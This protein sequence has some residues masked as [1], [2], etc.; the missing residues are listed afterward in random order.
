M[1][2]E[3][4]ESKRKKEWREGGRKGGGSKEGKT[5]IEKKIKY[6]EIELGGRQAENTGVNSMVRVRLHPTSGSKYTSYSCAILYL[7]HYQI[8]GI[9][10]YFAIPSPIP[11]LF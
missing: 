8:I 5:A 1:N 2:K 6:V 9:C 7:P 10:P 11:A 3:K 4:K